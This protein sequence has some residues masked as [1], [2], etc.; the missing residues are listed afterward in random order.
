MR[1]R[2]N[3]LHLGGLIRRVI[4]LRW[5][6]LRKEMGLTNLENVLFAEKKPVTTSKKNGYRFVVWD[7]ARKPKPFFTSAK[8]TIP[9]V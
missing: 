7:A 6:P 1:M 8:P 3:L 5:P 4:R 9:L 2:D